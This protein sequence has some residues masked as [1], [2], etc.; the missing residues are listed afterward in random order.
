MRRI[1]IS[2]GRKIC[3]EYDVELLVVPHIRELGNTFTIEVLL[4]EPIKNEQLSRHIEQADGLKNIPGIIDHHVTHIREWIKENSSEIQATKRDLAKIT[5]DNIE[6]YNHFVMGEDLIAIGDYQKARSEFQKSI[7]LDSTFGLAYYKLSFATGNASGEEQPERVL[8]AKAMLHINNL[9][10]K[11]RYLVQARKAWVARG[12]YASLEWLTEMEQLYPNE[13]EMLLAL[14]TA[15][16]STKNYDETIKYITK[17]QKVDP[18]NV[19]AFKLLIKTYRTQRQFDKALNS[20]EHFIKYDLKTGSIEAG[21]INEQDNNFTA[22]IENY[23]IVVKID[24]QNAEALSRLMT[25]NRKLGNYDEMIKYAKSLAYV[26]YNDFYFREAVFSFAYNGELKLAHETLQRVR[27]LHPERSAYIDL[28]LATIYDYMEEYEKAE[29]VVMP[30]FDKSQDNQ[31]RRM[32][33]DRLYRTFIYMGRYR[34]AIKVSDQQLVFFG[35][36]E[37]Y[38]AEIELRKA[39]LKIWAWN[40]IDG[41]YTEAHAAIAS[42]SNISSVGYWILLNAFY[43]NSNNPDSANRIIESKFENQGYFIEKSIISSLTGDCARAKFLVDSLESK[44]SGWEKTR[45][46]YHLSSCYIKNNHSELAIEHLIKLQSVYIHSP[47][48]RAVFYPKS[49]FL[50]AQEYEKIG[51]TEKAIKSYQKF[52]KLWENADSDLPEL[53]IA[54][55]KLSKLLNS[56]I[57]HAF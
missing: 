19:P 5:T 46:L 27:T 7:E 15:N 1:D 31:I 28:E 33:H 21:A 54:N 2:L 57:V 37:K 40:D 47:P 45:A 43:L 26:A 52:L 18:A 39:L 4:L 32:A 34:D 36:M 42:Q 6:A 14:A 35:E 49:F 12:P 20:A 9:P 11:Y 23:K 51:D 55:K 29:K 22:A 17:I 48:W 44:I 8:L 10:D 3:K 24:P 50:L 41:A 16:F 13:K 30:L 38:Q 53:I 25:I 56:N